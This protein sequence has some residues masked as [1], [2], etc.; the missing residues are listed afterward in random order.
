MTVVMIILVVVL[1]LGGPAIMF[2][3]FRYA[4]DNP[5]QK[6]EDN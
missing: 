4:S 2:F 1:A 5:G 6:G 3:A